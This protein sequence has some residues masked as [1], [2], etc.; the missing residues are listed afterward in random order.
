MVL[1]FPPQVT[2]I[3]PVL[4]APVFSST[5]RESIPF[6]FPLVGVTVS[7]DVALLEAVHDAFVLT[8]TELT[9]IDAGGAQEEAD[10]S[11]DG[12]EAVFG[13]LLK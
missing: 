2:V 1:L 12:D 4:E 13:K 8:F 3:I 9:L 10:N 11:S 6:P 7:Q 5:I